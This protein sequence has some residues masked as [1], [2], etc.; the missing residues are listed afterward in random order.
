[1]AGHV[2]HA[3][4]GVVFVAAFEVEARVDGHVGGR[5]FDVLVV[6]DVYAGRVVHLVIG[7]CGDGKSADG[8]L[9][10]VEHGVDVGR[11]D[12]LIIV[13]DGNSRIGP[14]QEGLRHLR[15]VIEHALDF[16]EGM[17]R[18]EGETC[19]AFLMEHA[20]HLADPYRDAAVGIFFDG[21]V[22][23]HVG[24]GAVVLRPVEL[25]A[26]RNP[27][28]GQAYQSRLDDMV[29]V[30]K[31]A[32]LYLVVSHL[33]TSTQFG[34]N[35][36]FDVFVLDEYGIVGFIGLF[37]GNGLDDRIGIDYA[38]AALINAFLQKHRAFFGFTHFVGGDGYLFFPGF[39]HSC[40]R[41]FFS[42]HSIS[43]R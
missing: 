19:H 40:M 20:L 12:A 34:Q 18:A 22:N 11:E 9:A 23:G 26:A 5:H 43:G 29:V 13:V 32:L 27:G 15:A 28:T 33:Y 16:E 42:S 37:V 6:R 4:L 8:P 36:D 24:A 41:C 38:A 17:P 10:M 2:E 1:M 31:V 14:P 21:G 7:A 30:D 39:D 25:D 35:H 3:G